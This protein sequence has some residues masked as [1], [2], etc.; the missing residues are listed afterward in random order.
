M[1]DFQKCVLNLAE[2][3]VVIGD[4]INRAQGEGAKKKEAKRKWDFVT[5]NINS[6]SQILNDE[7]N[8]EKIRD[9]TELLVCLE[10]L[11]AEKDIRQPDPDV[12]CIPM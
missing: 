2:Q 11:N 4:L 6:Y 1:S 7:K 10:I 9:Y 5:G 12:N 3:D 8:P